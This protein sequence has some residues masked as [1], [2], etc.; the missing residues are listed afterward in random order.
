MSNNSIIFINET[1]LPIIIETFQNLCYGIDK[2]LSILVK[3]G[4]NI[5]LNSST[6]EWFLTTY[7]FDKEMGNKWIT[8]GYTLGKT[9]G[10]FRNKPCI[11]G[12]YSW[13]DHDDFQISYDNDT[14]I[15]T[16]LHI[17]K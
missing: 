16:F 12:K 1:E 2:M 6:G 3:P 17:R 15:A 7:I 10:K 13:M 11:Q 14:E 4:G 8:A 9:I 5:I